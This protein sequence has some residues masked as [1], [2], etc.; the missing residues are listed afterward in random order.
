MKLG[1]NKNILGIAATIG[2]VGVIAAAVKKFDDF[3][4]SIKDGQEMILETFIDSLEA[5]KTIATH[6]NVELGFQAEAIH[7]IQDT[8][9][10]FSSIQDKIQK[11]VDVLAKKHVDEIV[12]DTTKSTK[13][14]LEELNGLMDYLKKNDGWSMRPTVSPGV[15]SILYEE[16]P[17]LIVGQ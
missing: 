11:T 1:I 10:K 15:G 2:A 8:L 17:H 6:N 12:E 14:I 7:D 4:D 16:E 9:G 5:V 13:Q 3:G